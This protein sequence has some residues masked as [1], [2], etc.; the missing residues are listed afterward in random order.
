[1]PRRVEVQPQYTTD[2]GCLCCSLKIDRKKFSLLVDKPAGRVHVSHQ[3]DWKGKWV[4]LDGLA[5][6][7]Y[8]VELLGHDGFA[9]VLALML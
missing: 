1:M 4:T 6:Q 3:A 7:A 2:E 5:G 8:L 9:K